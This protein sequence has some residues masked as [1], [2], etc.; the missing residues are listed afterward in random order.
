MSARHLIIAASS[1]MA[2]VCW[3]S[4]LAVADGVELRA[5]CGS[6][7]I[8]RT[9]SASP[10]DDAPAIEEQEQTVILQ[11]SPF[12]EPTLVSGP[13]V[14]APDCGPVCAPGH[15]SCIPPAL[16][17]IEGWAEFEYLVWW[18]SGRWF[19]PL[20]TTQ[21]NSGVL[22][23]T[24]V[25]FGGKISEQARAGG[26]LDIGVWLDPCRTLGLGGHYLAVG[27]APVEY[28]L[29]SDELGFFARPFTDV[30]TDPATPTAFPVANDAADLPTTG[31]LLL[32][33]S[34]EV[35]AADIFVRWVLR[36]SC[37]TQFDLLVGYQFSRL[38]EDLAID[39]FTL[40]ELIDEV[41]ETVSVSDIFDTHNEYHAAHFGFQGEYRRCRWGLDVSTR[42]G[43][44]NMRQRVTIRG[45]S[46][47]TDVT[48]DVDSRASGLL[49]QAATNAGV[50]T[51]DKFSFM[52][53]T[54]IKLNFYARERLK[55]SIGYSLMYW[56]SVVRPGDHIDLGI[57]GDLLDPIP[58]DDATRPA[59]AFNPTD[60]YL[61]GLN[62]GMEFSF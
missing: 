36:R 2:A 24:T 18:R 19:P 47:F 37:R 56:T 43:F 22:P 33:S 60:F 62:L 42:F 9:V 59:F 38:D 49:A 26:R 52:N 45:A 44:G 5:S 57:D 39:T 7:A 40:V 29:D 61:H 12:I 51:Q 53:D 48:G 31:N 58:P 54:G 32:R 3:L 20:V 8:V 34:S 10:V 35:Q 1:S 28:A 14:C 25:L 23:D 55:L 50:H 15:A 13:T 46:T 30:S 16:H 4:C 17:A 27:D 21:P 6:R 41:F 11:E